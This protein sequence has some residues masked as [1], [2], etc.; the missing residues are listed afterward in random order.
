[1]K[2]EV[3]FVKSLEDYLEKVIQVILKR[4]DS[5]KSGK[6]F[7]NI[8]LTPREILGAFLI[9][10]VVKYIS[11]QDWTLAR[12]IQI[13]DGIIWC[14]DKNRYGD[15]ILLEQV[16]VRIRP[17]GS[18]LIEIAEKIKNQIQRKVDKGKEYAKNRHLIVFLDVEG[19]FAPGI[20]RS[21]INNVHERFESY[22]LFA[23]GDGLDYSVFL[24]KAE[25]D[26]PAMYKVTINND[27]RGW[28]VERLEVFK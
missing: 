11:R 9:C 2:S 28:R 16:Y 25:K 20:L 14:R 19:E 22:W 1:M 6:R 4:P 3:F 15:V 18:N 10:V 21:F 23:P 13:G 24:L 5:L 12:D 26:N 8:K 7:T 27:F 17:K